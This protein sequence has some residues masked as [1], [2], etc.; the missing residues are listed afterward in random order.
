MG[1]IVAEMV[2]TAIGRYRGQFDPEALFGTFEDL[3]KTATGK[4]RRGELE[5]RAREAAD[6]DRPGG[7]AGEGT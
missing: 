6:A 3:P 7:G 4:L 5:E 1:S 2:G